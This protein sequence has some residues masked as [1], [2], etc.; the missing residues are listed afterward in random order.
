MQKIEPAC[1]KKPTFIQLRVAH[2]LAT[3]MAKEPSQAIKNLFSQR[4]HSKSVKFHA[5]AAALTA[6]WLGL[7]VAYRYESRKSK[8]CMLSVRMYRAKSFWLDAPGPLDGKNPV[9][10]LVNKIYDKGVKLTKKATA[11]SEKLIKRMPAY[12]TTRLVRTCRSYPPPTVND[13][14]VVSQF[15]LCRKLS[16]VIDS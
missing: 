9:V 6:S 3:V 7:C 4:N 1:K 14:P 5:R 8:Q 2:F 10:V 16:T 13:K 11:A 15:T 12:L